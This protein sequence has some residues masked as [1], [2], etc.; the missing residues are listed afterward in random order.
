MKA[1]SLAR[2]S[3][4]ISLSAIFATASFTAFSSTE[5]I[6]FDL[7]AGPW[8]SYA[9]GD[10]GCDY[11]IEWGRL[12]K[13]DDRLFLYFNST[14]NDHIGWMRYGYM[15]QEKKYSLSG[16]ALKLTFTGGALPGPNGTV[17]TEGMPIFDESK[18]N[19]LHQTYGAGVYATSPMPSAPSIF[20]KNATPYLN[21]LNVFKTQNRFTVNVLYP[22]ST[23]PYARVSRKNTNNAS[24]EK[25]LA[26]YPFIDDAK[27]SHYYHH[28]SNR[29]YGGWAKTNFDAHPTHKNAGPY[30][31]TYS[32]P[33][34]G[35]EAPYVGTDY[36]DRIAALAVRFHGVS[37]SKSPYSVLT[38][39]WSASYVQYENEETIANLG[40]AHD[41]ES[42]NFDISFED[43]YRC[44]NCV[45]QYAVRYSFAP[46]NSNNFSLA[47]TPTVNNFFIED[48]NAANTLIKPNP[49]YNL[50]WGFLKLP[51]VDAKR[52]ASGERIYFAVKDTSNRTFTHDP[53]DK[54]IVQTPWG[55]IR[56]MDL[57]KTI[58][59]DFVNPPMDPHLST[60]SIVDAP[61]TGGQLGIQFEFNQIESIQF[62]GVTTL[63]HNQA[64][65]RQG[66]FG[67]PSTPTLSHCGA[68][69]ECNTYKLLQGNI[70]Q[71]TNLSLLTKTT[72]TRYREGYDGVMQD[73]GSEHSRYSLTGSGFTLSDSDTVSVTIKNSSTSYVEI[74]PRARSFVLGAP[75][76]RKER[77]NF[78]HSSETLQPNAKYTWVFPAK[79]LAGNTLSGLFI[80]IPKLG[81]N[82]EILDV[83]FNSKAVLNCMSCG[84]LLVDFFGGAS[85]THKLPN[86]E[87]QTVFND[88]YTNEFNKGFSITIG[89]NGQYNYQGVQG[90]APLD[91]AYRH[92]RIVW[93]N[94][95]ITPQ[96]FSPKYSF[97][98]SDSPVNGNVGT[99]LT[100]NEFLLAPG[101]SVE[102]ILPLPSNVTMINVSVN[103]NN[104]R[105]I[106]ADTI[107]LTR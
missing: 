98:D 32:Y 67:L 94:D 16:D 55:D 88:R 6:N 71:F 7:D 20:L 28:S 60:S 38:D 37:G 58:H 36:F 34:G 85:G 82:I 15:S 25:T 66:F 11:L 86:A 42:G 3:I 97:D 61:S 69:L 89:S 9:A 4:L 22:R 68:T 23:N 33:E 30:N 14:N 56:K 59:A 17:I 52:F 62:G 39:D 100:S 73:S 63:L 77:R 10:R 81:P 13:N 35:S 46:I 49:G 91:A 18:F 107:R 93:R 54:S 87:W 5:I 105:T 76:I 51:Y 90:S 29:S 78:F 21:K 45:S 57:V 2:K 43:K 74:T 41:P 80:D 106:V 48:D 103:I 40:I 50:L 95:G 53:A 79:A 75:S 12:C 8:R 104:N 24:P 92:A 27:G 84:D 96:S 70:P 72:L 26:W 83:S 64:Y 65:Y 31:S 44:E 19:E 47:S 101:E 102:Q 99:W 1:L